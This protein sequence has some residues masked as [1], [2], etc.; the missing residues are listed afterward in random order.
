[1]RNLR[2]QL[3]CLAALPG[4]LAACA[5]GPDYERPAAAAPAA[6]KE[7]APPENDAP[8]GWKAAEPQEDLA[9]GD[10]WRIFD[11]AGL[12]ALEAELGIANQNIRLAEAQYRQA[13]AQA[14]AA[15]AAFFPSL[16]TNLDISRGRAAGSNP[17]GAVQ[18]SR[19]LSLDASWEADVWGRVRRSVEAGEASAAASAA[20]LENIR[21]SAQA[22]LA[23]DYFLL[24]INAAEKRLLEATVA[25]YAK[26]LEL[27]QNLYA[28][29]VGSAADVAQAETQLKTARAQAIDL[30]VQRAQLEHAIA[31]LIGKPPAALVLPPATR[32]AELPA[33]PVG[34]PSQ[35]L[36]RRPDIAAAERRVA[37][38]NA[39]IGVA[40]AAFFPTL[41]LSAQGGFMSNA[42]SDWLTAPQ[43]F[44]SLGPALAQSLFDGGLRRAQSEAAEAAYDA[45]VAS[46]RQTVLAGFQEVEDNLAALRILEHEAAAQNDAVQAARKSVALTTNQYQAGIVSYL[47]VMSA[48]TVALNNERTALTLHGRRLAAAV[49]L[50]RA[51]GGGWRA[52]QRG[53]EPR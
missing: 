8:A 22:E 49:V 40:R 32:L 45:T 23:Q 4:L 52:T 25:A 10:W 51:L 48:E 16:A 41:M 30:D 28:A 36:E 15:R 24:Q 20:D 53:I 50:V 6:Y 27:T 11:D 7:N 26:T 34:L 47:N 43:R 35:L 9:K 19:S 44:W 42:A 38:A 33:I 13:R 17:G 39:Q 1:M 5:V 18:T 31:T 29:G 14:N 21:L 3:L 46:Y 12:D 2:T 37:A